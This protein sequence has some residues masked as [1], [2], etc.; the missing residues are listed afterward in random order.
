MAPVGSA[1]E[2]QQTLEQDLQTQISEMTSRQT[3]RKYIFSYK[4]IQIQPFKNMFNNRNKITSR[5]TY[6]CPGFNP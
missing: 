6:F 1:T 2:A 4:N 3:H 5:P